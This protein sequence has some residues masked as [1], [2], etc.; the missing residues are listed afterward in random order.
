MVGF[1][2]STVV[3]MSE[4]QRGSEPDERLQPSQ[5]GAFALMITEFSSQYKSNL[6]CIY[7]WS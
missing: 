4:I 7:I 6:P 2:E 3:F 5:A 1:Q